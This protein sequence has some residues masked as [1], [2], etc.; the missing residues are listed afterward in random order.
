VIKSTG[1]RGNA[2]EDAKRKTPK[3]VEM[4][5][6]GGMVCSQTWQ[7][8]QALVALHPGIC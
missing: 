6:Y 8:L 7:Q 1:T 5:G 4:K 2:K 3:T